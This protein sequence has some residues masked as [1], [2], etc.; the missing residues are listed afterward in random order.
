MRSKV[1]AGHLTADPASDRAAAY[2]HAVRT[3]GIAYA[4]SIAKVESDKRAALAP[5][6]ARHQARVDALR[7][8]AAQMIAHMHASLDAET[9]KLVAEWSAERQRIEADYDYVAADA[10]EIY[11]RTLTL[12]R[13][14]WHDDLASA[15]AGDP[16]DPA[17]YGVTPEWAADLESP[18]ADAAP[19]AAAGQDDPPF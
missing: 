8:Y 19:A 3:A 9:A 1:P 11:D 10:R 4:E 2:E 13:A 16:A 6:V 18:A 12:A 14:A 5:M 15:P 7:D 17:V